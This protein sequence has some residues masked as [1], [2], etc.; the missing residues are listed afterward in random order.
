LFTR[1]SDQTIDAI[2]IDLNMNVG[3]LRG[4]MKNA[5]RDEKTPAAEGR[6]REPLDAAAVNVVVACHSFYPVR[7]RNRERAGSRIDLGTTPRRF[8]LVHH[9]CFD[10]PDSPSS[11]CPVSG[12]PTSPSPAFYR[13]RT[14]PVELR[15]THWI[16]GLRVSRGTSK[17]SSRADESPV[18]VFSDAFA[19]VDPE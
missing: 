10:E 2:A 14:G 6:K 15:Q 16:G 3:I 19:A 7:C 9:K 12:G 17:I 11:G 5:S 13:F 1:S 18:G 8:V 4:W